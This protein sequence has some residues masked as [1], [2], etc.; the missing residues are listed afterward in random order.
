LKHSKTQ[1]LTYLVPIKKSQQD[2][3]NNIL[4]DHQIKS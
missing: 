2:D 1:F 4:K 3:F